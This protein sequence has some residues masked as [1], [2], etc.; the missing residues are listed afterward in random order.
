MITIHDHLHQAS[1]LLNKTSSTP[2]LDASLLLA[3][4]LHQP[5]LF[6]LTY[7]T[8]PLTTLQSQQFQALIQKRQAGWPIAYLIG[9]REFW[10]LPLMV[11]PHTLIPRPE[12]ECLVERVLTHLQHIAHP[13]ILELGT[14]S[15]AIAL[16]LASERPDSHITAVDLSS[17]AL[18]LAKH[19][20]NRL[21]FQH[22][23][24]Q[25]ADWFSNLSPDDRFHL[26]VSNPPYV[27]PDDPHLAQGDLR[28][29]PQL[30]L[31]SQSQG[32]AALIHII[33]QACPYLTSQ[34][35]LCLEHGYNQAEKVRTLLVQAG[36]Q[37]VQTLC[38]L[39]GHERVSEGRC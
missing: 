11:S 18:T 35:W 2:K 1:T 28:Y 21:G 36:Y 7:P 3:F 5:T 29:E 25:H 26:I 10:S 9:E 33:Q 4:T 24:F 39:Q 20:A 8:H 15:G 6:L 38:D 27:A 16:A 19:N 37:D 12:T 14:G 32:F 22:I 17:E 23:R 30:A 31:V 34:G 13:M